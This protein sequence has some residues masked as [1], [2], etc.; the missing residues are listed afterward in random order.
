V[1]KGRLTSDNNSKT[2]E[3][4]MV[5]FQIY[6]DVAGQ[7]R[8]RLVAANGEIVAVSEAYTTKYGAELS[9]RRVKILAP[10]AII[11]DLTTINR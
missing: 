9:A 3:V 11:V 5:K 10:V 4:I 8:W 1:N 7:Y 2:T 6:R